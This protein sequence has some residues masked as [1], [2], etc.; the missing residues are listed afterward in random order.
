M[1]KQISGD[2]HSSPTRRDLLNKEARSN[3]SSFLPWMNY[4]QETGIYTNTDDTHGF[5]WECR[6][7]AFAG[8]STGQ[9]LEGLFRLNLP[10]GSIMQF[11]LCADSFI[12][13][14]LERY[15]A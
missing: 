13:P 12:D 15:R 3:F 6:P 4:E 10:F 9:V 7:L 8:D 11:T 2:T 5:L 1:L 14:V